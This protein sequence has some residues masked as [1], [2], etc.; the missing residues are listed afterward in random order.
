MPVAFIDKVDVEPSS[1]SSSVSLSS[2]SS[3]RAVAMLA[4][5]CKVEDETAGECRKSRPTLRPTRG[6]PSLLTFSICSADEITVSNLFN[7]SI[8]RQCIPRKTSRSLF[9]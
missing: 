8:E 5:D 7:K 9:A 1:A 4:M 6:G 2:I 3:T